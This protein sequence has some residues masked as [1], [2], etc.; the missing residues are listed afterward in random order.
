MERNF[1]LKTKE[2][3]DL[4]FNHAEKMPIFDY[5]CHISPKEIAENKQ[6]KNLYE[7]WLSGDHYKWRQMRICGVDEKFITGDAPDYE[8]YCA[9]AEILP[10]MP[11]NPIYTWCRL[12]LKAYFNIDTLLSKETAKEI[13]DKTEEMLKSMTVRDII[14][15]SNVHT[16]CTTDD[17]ADSLEYHE[18]I[19]A[20]KSF[21]TR[22]LPAFRPDR[23]LAIEKPDFADYI[24]SLGDIKSLSDLKSALLS[25]LDYFIAHGCIAADCGMEYIPFSPASDNECDEIFKSA[26]SCLALDDT[27]CEKYKTNLLLFLLR[28]FKEKNIVSEL[29]CGVLR[30]INPPAFENIGA[31]AGFD[32]IASRSV[33]NLAKLLGDAENQNSLPKCIIYSLN[34]AD[35]SRILSI[36]GAFAQSGVRGKIQQGSAWWFNDTKEGMKKQIQD[37]SELSS[38][39]A[40][41]G[42]L[43]DSRSFLS[44]TRHEYF[45]RI[46]CDYI[47]GLIASG[48]YPDIKAAG[49]IVEDICFNNAEKFFSSEE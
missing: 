33:E 37:F 28:A 10:N 49:K 31:D 38:L 47:G 3:Q 11:G 36:C 7:L 2:A 35:N 26:L 23:A 13:W 22:V 34:P 14:E 17:P 6:F 4:Y 18:I 30:N 24:A 25:R 45:R 44:Y 15:K 8:K 12:E 40:F 1:L 5:H 21:K 42:M 29:H 19:A 43:T 9:F 20:D 48:E 39:G 27:D 46:L 41:V 16:I 32:V